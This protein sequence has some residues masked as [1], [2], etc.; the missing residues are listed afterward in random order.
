MLLAIRSNG[1]NPAN[2]RKGVR[3]HAISGLWFASENLEGSRACSSAASFL[4]GWIWR[5]RAW[6]MLERDGKPEGETHP[7]CM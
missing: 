6:G 2:P 3:A 5:G 1:A 4:S 7:V